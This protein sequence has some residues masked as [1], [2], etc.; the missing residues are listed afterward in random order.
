M[1]HHDIWDSDLAGAPALIDARHGG[2][3]IPAV[4][5]VS[6]NGLL[7]LLYRVTGT[8]IYGVEERAV[9]NSEIPLERTA[10]TQPFPIK[11]AP[12][13]RM[14]MSAADIATVTPEYIED[15]RAHVPVSVTVPEVLRSYLG[16]DRIA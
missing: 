12:L 6:K 5:V 4:A 11:P 1:V 8:P 10:K 16:R 15:G 3:T 2:K 7:F 14:T 13:A 9:P